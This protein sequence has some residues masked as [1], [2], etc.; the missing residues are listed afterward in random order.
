ML[1]HQVVIYVL[2][3]GASFAWLF[4]RIG[5]VDVVGYIIGGMFLA[6]I[7]EV[8][9]LDIEPALSYT[10]LISWIGLVL[11]SFKVGA[12]IN[13]RLLSHSFNRFIA[14]ELV[15]VLIQWI[16]SGFI[17]SMLGF[18]LIARAALFFVLVNSSSIAVL[19]IERV[20][21]EVVVEAKNISYIQT[22]LEDLIQFT[23]FS[24]FT[25]VGL[26]GLKPEA[27]LIQIVKVGALTMLLIYVSRYFIKLL[28]RSPLIINKEGKFFTSIAIALIFTSVATLLGLPPLFGA[29]VS[30]IVFSL[31]LDLSDIVE[32]LEGLKDFGLLLYFSSLGF[33][34]YL[35]LNQ[36]QNLLSLIS[37]GIFIGLLA[38]L[39]RAIGVFVGSLLSGYSL[40]TCFALSLFLTPL[41]EVGIM[42]IDTLA[43][44]GF[45]L[46]YTLYLLMT[47]FLTSLMTFSI[48]VPRLLIRIPQLINLVPNKISHFINA[49]SREYTK[50]LSS[51]SSTLINV[52]VFTFMTLIISYIDAIMKYF[53]DIIH[54][55]KFLSAISTI[56]SVIA[57]LIMFVATMKRILSSIFTRFST[58]IKRIESLGKLFDIAIGGLA[59]TLQIQI[60]HDFVSRYMVIEPLNILTISLVIAI[61]II[62]LYDL[63]MTI[64]RH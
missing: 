49:V 50:L 59:V 1:E 55:P 26:T 58:D 62:T 17:A 4:R 56:I 25:S 30:G 46:H 47:S 33:Q 31:F 8:L 13:F 36:S 64:K 32:R 39:S 57:I 23:L 18:D 9:G 24:V 52:I 61:I 3:L 10:E 48:T 5:L 11:F 38:Y 12:S 16:A 6:L 2:V 54:L 21:V 34:F 7:M 63:A 19:A 29:F 53:I 28:S 27:F 45:I 60:L 20:N 15:V 42:F 14:S 51:L 40:E 41:S 43:K 22:Q 44:Q 35:G 37:S